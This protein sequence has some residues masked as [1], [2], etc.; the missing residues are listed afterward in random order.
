M[1]EFCDRDKFFSQTELMHQCNLNDKNDMIYSRKQKFEFET[2][3]F[4]REK[5][6]DL[7]LRFIFFSSRNRSQNIQH[8]RYDKFL[9]YLLSVNTKF[10]L[11]DLCLP[12]NFTNDT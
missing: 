9:I 10:Q 12:N 5:D 4:K 8:K 7:S 11:L 1:I 3:I 6:S 2:Q